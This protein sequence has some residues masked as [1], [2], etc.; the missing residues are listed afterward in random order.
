[1]PFVFKIKLESTLRRVIVQE[2]NDG[3]PD[4]TFEELDAK[5]RGMFQIPYSSRLVITYTDQDNEIVTMGDDLDLHDACIVQRINPLRMEVKVAS[6]KLNLP[7]HKEALQ[8]KSSQGTSVVE[9]TFMDAVKKLSKCSSTVPSQLLS[10]VVEGLMKVAK[11][12]DV[13]R[14]FHNGVQC[15]GCG[16]TPLVGPR[17]KSI[18]QEGYDLCLSCFTEHRDQSDYQRIDKPIHPQ[19]SHYHHPMHRGGMTRHPMFPS[20]ALPAVKPL[21]PP[22]AP[23]WRH[24][25]PGRRHV[26]CFRVN[27]VGQRSHRRLD[28]RFVQHVTI[29][30]GTEVAVGTIFTKIW[31]LRN[32]GILP[33]PCATQLVC[34]GG[35]VLGSERPSMLEIPK[36][37]LLCEEEIDASVDLV[38]PERPGRFVS[39]WRLMTP[40]GQKFGQRIWVLIQVVSK[41]EQ[42]VQACH[43]SPLQ[44][45]QQLEERE[46]H[47]GL[48]QPVLLMDCVID[49]K[50]V[51]TANISRDGASSIKDSLISSIINPEASFLLA[52]STSN[53]GLSSVKE[54]MHELSLPIQQDTETATDFDVVKSE[55]GGFSLIES[56]GEISKDSTSGEM[57]I[58]PLPSSQHL[59]VPVNLED[60]LAAMHL[61]QSQSTEFR[62]VVEECEFASDC[63]EDI[64]LG[65]LNSMGFTQ[66]TL[67]LELLRKNKNDM[68]GTVDDLVVASEWD[69][70]LDDLEEMGFYDAEMNRRLLSKNNGSVKLVVKELLQMQSSW[71]ESQG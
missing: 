11:V 10:G 34:V 45:H 42:S 3:K 20:L 58:E 44:S 23:V 31:R 38:A 54:S 48:D 1:M 7:D 66:R 17:F 43:P 56:P 14:V 12:E 36:H 26:S 18:K 35:D 15:D 32:V 5:I 29:F 63:Q 61:E 49:N 69:H 68:Q 70:M 2:A 60:S 53:D 55:V 33:W 71:G 67:N 37:G 50:A 64:I 57:M 27:R 62:P 6:A 19:R 4:L 41:G 13:P 59:A 21:Y 52:A 40:S 8:T 28:S 47:K 65:M 25:H 9:Q 51:V 30:D 24:D 16:M 39:Y 22:R 46:G